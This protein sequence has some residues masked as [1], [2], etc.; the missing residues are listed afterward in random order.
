MSTVVL[1]F[2]GAAVAS[3]EHFRRISEIILE[4]KQSY[5]D[6]VV[7]VSA[8]A[9]TTDKLIALAEEVNPNPPRRELDMLVTVGERVSISLLA[10]A[11]AVVGEEA[12]SF[13]GSQSGIITSTDHTDGR[14]VDVRP[15][16]IRACLEQ[17]KIAIVAGFQGVSYQG[18][19]TTLGRGGSDT[20]AVALGAALG[21][22]EVLFYKDVDGIYDCDPKKNPHA[23]HYS[24]LSYQEALALIK[25]GATVL[26]E[27]SVELAEKNQL[28]L[29]ITTF[30]DQDK[31]VRSYIC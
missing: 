6:V 31:K 14:I 2:G 20:S 17:G 12:M 1:K 7:V 18:E 3:P 8:M 13:T 10:M 22:E 24:Q 16:R 30:H 21:A 19:I 15:Q 29:C 5:S 28:P 9:D 25:E 23:K 27:R 11:L 4:V 26:Q